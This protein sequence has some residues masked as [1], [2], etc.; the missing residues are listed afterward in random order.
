M[1]TLTLIKALAALPCW[2]ISH[3][4]TATNSVILR[5]T[6]GEVHNQMLTRCDLIRRAKKRKKISLA[7]VFSSRHLM[8]HF[9]QRLSEMNG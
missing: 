6:N 3:P 2:M 8:E 5:A 4:H 1:K 7:L 9:R